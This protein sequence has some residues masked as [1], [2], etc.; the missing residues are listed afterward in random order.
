[1]K[2]GMGIVYDIN[3]GMG[4]IKSGWLFRDII[5][6]DNIYI[7]YSEYWICFF[8]LKVLFF[9]CLNINSFYFFVIIRVYLF[10]YFFF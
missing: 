4:Y 2:G 9:L 5:S 10:I 7:F 1:M 6:V 3:N 8:M